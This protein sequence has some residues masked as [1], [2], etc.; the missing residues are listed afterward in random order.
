MPAPTTEPSRALPNWT[1]RSP[2]LLSGPL[3]TVLDQAFIKAYVPRGAG[4]KAKVGKCPSPAPPA[5]ETP[6]RTAPQAEAV[7]A[8]TAPTDETAT[9]ITGRRGPDTA[10]VV[11]PPVDRFMAALTGRYSRPGRRAN[12]GGRR[13]A[14]GCDDP[15]GLTVGR[16]WRPSQSLGHARLIPA[17]AWL[18]PFRLLCRS[19]DRT[20]GT[21]RPP[22]ECAADARSRRARCRRSAVAE[23]WQAELQMDR[24]FWPPVC[25][26]LAAAAGDALKRLA[27]ALAC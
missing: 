13:A 26:Q 1:A 10:A 17:V 3:M 11:A 14:A 16:D 23:P 15:P 25:E 9:S 7:A 19:G 18:H 21:R 20:G 12:S 22:D 5:T 6:A 4:R 24:F 2:N 27:D 8:A